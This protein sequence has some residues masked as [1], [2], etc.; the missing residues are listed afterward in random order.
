MKIAVVGAG[1]VGGYF[2]ARLAAAGS[3]VAFIGRGAHLAAM[4]ERGLA[5]LSPL[6]DVYLEKVK[7]ADNPATVGPV[8][9]VLFAVKLYDTESAGAGLR[10]LLGPDTVVVSLQNGIDSED[11]LGAIIGAE[12]VAGG[13]AY[14][15]ATIETPG[16]IRHLNRQAKLAFGE[17]GDRGSSRLEPLLAACRNAGFEAE[18]NSS[19]ETAI[20]EKF[21]FLAAL[22][23][24][25]G[26]ARLPI[27]PLVTDADT[28]ALIADAMR[29]V[30]AVGQAKGVALDPSIVDRS[31][32]FMQTLPP[33]MKASLAH[34][35]DKGNRLEIEGLSGAVVRLGA[36]LGVA[37]PVHRT[38]YALLK[39]H[40][41]GR[42]GTLA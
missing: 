38:I 8:D 19:I 11:R 35:L 10:P 33:D 2:G 5:V 20:W 29:E 27:G 13:I 18:L 15:S 37:T 17:L 21:V 14:I 34:D 24:A 30:V 7:A 4:Q 40:G 25:T 26:G 42:A 6:G 39:L 12:R 22:A 16:V 31:L 3:D 28:R 36:S 41:G 23:A 32:A 9:A 1:G